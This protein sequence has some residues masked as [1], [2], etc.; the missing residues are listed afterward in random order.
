MSYHQRTV[1][2]TVAEVSLGESDDVKVHRLVYAMECGRPVNRSGIEAQIQG[3]AMWALS[4]LMGKEITFEGGRVQQ[5]GFGDFPVLTM[6]GA[7]AIEA[8]IL[9]SELPPFG[10]GEQPVVTVIPAVLNAVAAAGGRR[11]DRVPL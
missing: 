5:R 4:T 10:V 11:V 7:P 6:A 8:H 3:G 2:S 1:V 9:D